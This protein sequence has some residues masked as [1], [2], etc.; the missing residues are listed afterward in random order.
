MTTLPY[1][2]T[3]YWHPLV[4]A[5]DRIL[6]DL[7][8]SEDVVQN[9]FIKARDM[10]FQCEAEARSRLY[11]V[12]LNEAR[13]VYRLRHHT[14]P[15]EDYE[16]VL[17]ITNAEVLRRLMIEIDKLPRR[18]R[19][20]ILLQLDGQSNKQIGI[21]LGITEVCARNHKAYGVG[22]LRLAMR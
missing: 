18:A 16:D 14:C 6:H 13:N 11:T 12:A 21:A 8:A 4:Y 20:V 5:A 2:F 15:V 7:P 3:T 22:L 1:L 10:I 9:T 19:E 17:Q